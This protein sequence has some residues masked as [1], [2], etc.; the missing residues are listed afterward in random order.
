MDVLGFLGKVL[1][2]NDMDKREL[3]LIFQHRSRV[4]PPMTQNEKKLK[5]KKASY[6][7]YCSFLEDEIIRLVNANEHNNNQNSKQNGL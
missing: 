7:D 2:Q 1:I 6:Q 4:Y 5:I 3:R